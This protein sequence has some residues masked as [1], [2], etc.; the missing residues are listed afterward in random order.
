MTKIPTQRSQSPLVDTNN[1][2]CWLHRKGFRWMYMGLVAGTFLFLKAFVIADAG[3][4]ST[5]VLQLHAVVTFVLLHWV[6]GD[7]GDNSRPSV[8]RDQLYGQTFWEQIDEGYFGTPTR[9]F[10]QVAPIVLFFL[11]LLFN[12]FRDD[13]I[14]LFFNTAATL[15]CIIPKFETLVGVRIFG[16]N[17]H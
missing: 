13:M 7:A 6:Q 1:N 10:L 9:R 16:I 2:T 15:L 11:S 5:V 12:T 8:K 17:K 14:T 4:C 3:L